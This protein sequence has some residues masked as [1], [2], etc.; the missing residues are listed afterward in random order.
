MLTKFFNMKQSLLSVVM[1]KVNNLILFLPYVKRKA[2]STVVE[3]YLHLTMQHSVWCGLREGTGGITIKSTSGSSSR[4][5]I[6][7][8]G[9]SP[10]TDHYYWR[11][12]SCPRVG[13][14]RLSRPL[15]NC[16]TVNCKFFLLCVFFLFCSL[17]YSYS[18]M[19][20]KFRYY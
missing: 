4:L 3:L 15:W 13:S 16:G 5:R 12:W 8:V 18:L 19:S 9:R 20:V 7:F 6:Y 11:I 2:S 14:L 17:S 10:G 1:A